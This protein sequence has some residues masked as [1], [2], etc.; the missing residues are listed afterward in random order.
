MSILVLLSLLGAGSLASGF[1]ADHDSHHDD[2]DGQDDD[3]HHALA[4]RRNH[5]TLRDDRLVVGRSDLVHGLAG[6]DTITASG[7]GS[8]FGDTGR[9]L[10]TA[11]GHSTAHGGFGD[12]SLSGSDH[13]TVYGDNNDDH[14]SASGKA[15]AFGG[16]GNDTII[17]SSA[18]SGSGDGGD[19]LIKIDGGGVANGGT[20]DDLFRIQ[21]VGH[22][23][24]GQSATVLTGGSG[25]DVFVVDYGSGL[26]GSGATPTTITDFDPLTDRLIIEASK[27]S[28]FFPHAAPMMPVITITPDTVANHVDLTVDWGTLDGTISTSITVRLAGISDL[29]P[30]KVEL[31]AALP[32]DLDSTDDPV[33]DNVLAASR[34]TAGGDTLDG[35]TDVVLQTGA[36]ADH[37][38]SAADGL[39]MANLGAGNDTFTATGAEIHVLG[40]EGDDLFTMDAAAQAPAALQHFG[41]F[42]GGDGQDTIAVTATGSNPADIRLFGETGNDSMSAGSGTENVTLYGGSGD[43]TLIA[44]AGTDV[45]T[46]TYTLYSGGQPHYAGGRVVMNISADDFDTSDISTV[47][48]LLPDSENGTLTVHLDPALTGEITSEIASGPMLNEETGITFV[49]TRFMVGGQPFLQVVTA[50]YDDAA[51]ALS[52][53]DPRIVFDRTVQTG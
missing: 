30:A 8:A 24:F 17:M 31:V 53:T 51:T 41:A 33:L 47:S 32:F 25:A 29:D 27:Q 19:D 38:T 13:S 52:V 45:F 9:D 12:D 5:G 42:Y 34:G 10:I 16:S 49:V 40:G 37:V 28:S 7:F 50:H 14:I 1:L 43:D 20:G 23:D 11:R 4:A 39:M 48:E 21:G 2:P 6:D 26:S 22:A 18:M 3:N 44:N 15:V 36:G 35:L 46:D